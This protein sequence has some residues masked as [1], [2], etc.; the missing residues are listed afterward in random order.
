LYN[1]VFLPLAKTAFFV[2]G[3]INDKLAR[4][5]R[6]VAASWD[7]LR[8]LPR[9]KGPR[10][11][12]HAAS[13]GEFE[14]AKPVIE[15]LKEQRPEAQ[16]IVSFFSPSGYD[17]Q[18]N[19]SFADAVVYLPLDTRG[20]MRRFV[21]LL[22]PDAAVFV[23]YDIWFNVLAELHRQ[24]IPALLIC[25]TLNP[26]SFLL[27]STLAAFT[28]KAYSFFTK[29][30]TAGIGET[31]QFIQHRL[32]NPEVLITAADTRFDRILSQ[33]QHAAEHPVLPPELFSPGDIVL[34]AGSTWEPDED[35]LLQAY[36]RLSEPYRSKL[37]IIM[38]PHE[39][40]ETTVAR[41]LARLPGA[42]KLSTIEAAIQNNTTPEFTHIIVDSIG[43]LL[44]LYNHAHCAYI[45]GGFGVGVHSVTEPAGYG[46]PL[47]C[48]PAISRAR[49]AIAL[50][51]R[52]AL[53][54]V[55][56]GND[57]TEW[58]TSIL[59]SPSTREKRGSV[60]LEYLHS[61]TG[62]STTIARDILHYTESNVL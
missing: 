61:A 10:I 53:Y 47:A 35:V 62:Y 30:Y 21:S 9:A 20:T 26:A 27:S 19:Y 59:S 15:K 1:A 49:D 29:I 44:R 41:L 8:S 4:R 25:A 11:W 50:H 42:A 3:S 38:V 45:G 28:R 12:F 32:V 24:H 6:G 23:R 34:V 36:E 39:P 17:N 54:V 60:A 52:G 48:G 43:K 56:D 16:I 22:K 13:M 57:A 37:R 55:K 58:L 7:I 31:E 18:K 5:V 46:I 33:V 40:N 14:Q 2:G 51:N